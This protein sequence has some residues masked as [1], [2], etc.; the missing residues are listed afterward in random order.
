VTHLVRV[1]KVVL[2]EMREKVDRDSML[3][4]FGKKIKKG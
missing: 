3:K 1:K 2:R 4:C